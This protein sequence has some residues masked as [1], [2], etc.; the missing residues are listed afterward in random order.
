MSNLYSN[1]HHK[2]LIV[3]LIREHISIADQQQQLL[4]NNICPSVAETKMYVHTI[5]GL[6]MCNELSL[7]NAQLKELY[8][9]KIKMMRHELNG[10]SQKLEQ[11]KDA[12]KVYSEKHN[13]NKTTE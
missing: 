2:N 12:L 10:L 8:Y 5:S 6:S 7:R 9:Y 1:I 3:S 11:F 13:R 4:E